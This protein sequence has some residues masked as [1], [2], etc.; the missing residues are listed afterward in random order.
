MPGARPKR[1]ELVRQVDALASA[2]AT[3]RTSAELAAVT[4]L[5]SRTVLRLLG[6]MPEGYVVHTRETPRQGRGAPIRHYLVEHP[7]LP[8]LAMS[9]VEAGL[10]AVRAAR[11]AAGTAAPPALLRHLAR[12]ERALAELIRPGPTAPARRGSPPPRA[13]SRGGG[14]ARG[15]PR[16]GD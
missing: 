10:A 9:A 1:L 14:A 5:H 6:A 12:A 2:A 13:R 15:A 3:W 16:S 7:P 11:A 4:G 8:S